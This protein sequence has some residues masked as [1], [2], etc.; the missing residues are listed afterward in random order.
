MTA[1]CMAFA[2]AA[3]EGRCK[4][5]YDESQKP[6]CSHGFRPAAHRISAPMPEGVTSGC[7]LPFPDSTSP[8]TPGWKSRKPSASIMS[9]L[10]ALCS[11]AARLES[12][13]SCGPASQQARTI[14]SPY[15]SLT[16]MVAHAE[17]GGI[18]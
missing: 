12:I 14:E 2:D 4:G 9:V 16:R 8:E 10:L 3:E 7:R 5:C 17:E 15:N 6:R 18:A 11:D 13:S 1:I